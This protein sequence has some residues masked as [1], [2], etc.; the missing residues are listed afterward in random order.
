MNL[1]SPRTVRELLARHG[2]ETK[3]SLGQNFLVDGNTLRRIVEAAEISPEDSVLEIGTGLGILTRELARRAGRVVTVEIDRSLAPVL[4]ETLRDLVNIQQV[5]GDFLKQP[6]AELLPAGDNWKVV[7]N[8]PYYI[9]T[10]ILFRLLE[11]PVPLRRLVFLVQK[12]VAQRAAALPGGKTYGALSVTLQHRCQV[13]VAGLVPPTVFIPPPKVDSAIL[14][15]TPLARTFPEE[16][17]GVFRKLVE[18]AFRYRRK[19]LANAWSKLNLDWVGPAELNSVWST[20]KID[21][22][23][24]GECLSI[25]EFEAVAEHLLAQRR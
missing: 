16:A 8:L 19:T 1:A 12:E 3:K 13:Q 22:G 23:I 20:L 11:G 6:L 14:V 2:L 24:R 4:E 25:A 5:F 7:A 21:P 18:T 9:T 10:P 15:L 17:E